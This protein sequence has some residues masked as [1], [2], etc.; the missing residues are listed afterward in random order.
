MGLD[1]LP[2]GTTGKEPANAGDISDMGSTPGSGRSPEGGH[3][4]PLQSLAKGIPWTV[5]PGQLQSIG[6][7]RVR[8]DWSD[9][10][11]IRTWCDWLQ[12]SYFLECW[13]L[14]QVFYSLYHLHQEA[15]WFLFTFCPKD[16][17]ICITEVIDISPINLD[18]SLWFIQPCT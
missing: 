14:S 11:C 17:V 3:A 5:E 6:S 18:S 1:R 4:N 15:L 7:Q 16:G 10:T 13:N 2:G 8:H 9:L 12:W